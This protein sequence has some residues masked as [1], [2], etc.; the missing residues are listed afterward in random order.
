MSRRIKLITRIS[1][2]YLAFV[3]LSLFLCTYLA[4]NAG[5]ESST[6]PI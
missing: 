4:G 1:N 2:D 3:A 6:F 5:E